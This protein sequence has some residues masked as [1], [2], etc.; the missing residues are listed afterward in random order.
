MTVHTPLEAVRVAAFGF[1]RPEGHGAGDCA[2]NG[3]GS[4]REGTTRPTGGH[5]GA[6]GRTAKA[7]RAGEIMASRLAAIR[8]V[9]LREQ[10]GD[11]VE[12]GEPF[13]CQTVRILNGEPF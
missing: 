13:P 1:D 10:F 4:G 9:H 6:D 3:E 2:A 7:L 8:R 12:D 5:E 11:C